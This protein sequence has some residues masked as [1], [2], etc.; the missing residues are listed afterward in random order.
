M[1]TKDAMLRGERGVMRRAATLLMN[2]RAGYPR[3]EVN[4]RTAL[5]PFNRMLPR[6]SGVEPGRADKLSSAE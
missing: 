3:P 1:H 6:T 4:R 5:P 2:P